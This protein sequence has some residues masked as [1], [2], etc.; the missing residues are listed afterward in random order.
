M[1]LACA[2]ALP[3][4]ASRCYRCDVLSAHG[5]TC[6]RCRPSALVSAN[7]A[8]MYRDVVK[9][10]VWKLKFGRAQSAAKVMAAI[11]AERYSHMIADDVLIV[12]VPT[13]TKRVRSRGYDQAVLIA[14]ALAGQTGHR[15]ASL[16]IRVGAQEQIGAGKVQR[17]EQLQGVFMVRQDSLVHDA[18]ILLIDDVMTTGATLETAAAVL[19]QAGAKVVG[20]LVFARAEMHNEVSKN[21]AGLEMSSNNFPL[22]P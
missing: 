4:T 6:F 2:A 9:D 8:V 3:R 20:S 11:M 21:S 14:K 15:Y 5:R 18:R 13:A 1:C 12:P 17:K 16:L 22:T 19:R 7:A 10:L